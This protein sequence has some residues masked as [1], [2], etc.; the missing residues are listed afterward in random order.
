MQVEPYIHE[1]VDVGIVK[2]VTAGMDSAT[3]E[4]SLRLAR[5][6]APLVEAAIGIHPWTVVN[7]PAINS[8]AIKHLAEKSRGQFVAIGEIGLDG[9]YSS[10]PGVVK[11]Q[12]EIFSEMLE[13]AVSHSVPVVVHS[14]LAVE[15]VLSELSKNEPPGVLLHW[16]SGPTDLLSDCADRGYMI[17]VGPP[18]AYS[19]RII[20][21]VKSASLEMLLTETDAPVKYYGPFRGRTTSSRFVREVVQ[22]LAK[23]KDLSEEEVAGQIERNF[24]RLFGRTT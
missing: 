24:R 7:N 19:K 12:R 16:Y 3:S 15:Q 2:M 1:A 4:I 11:T 10:N 18:V 22:H 9:Q 8:D 6:Q 20:E 13:I 21:I 17:S 5:E 14:R 23:I